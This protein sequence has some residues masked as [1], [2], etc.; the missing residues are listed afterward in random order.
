MYT[1]TLWKNWDIKWAMNGQASIAEYLDIKAGWDSNKELTIG[2]PILPAPPKTI[3]THWNSTLIISFEKNRPVVKLLP[4]LLQTLL[5]AG[6]DEI[7]LLQHDFD[8]VDYKTLDRSELYE[9]LVL[10][11]AAGELSVYHSYPRFIREKLTALHQWT[12]WNI[13]F[14]EDGYRWLD[15]LL[16]VAHQYRA[17]EIENLKKCL[18]HVFF[19]DVLSGNESK[20]DHNIFRNWITENGYGP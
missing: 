14:R 2:K 6:L 15:N 17:A 20:I 12:G 18:Q 1:E 3:I 8:V 16:G 9:F 10:D 5:N 11:E 7:K 13:N 19:S 4:W